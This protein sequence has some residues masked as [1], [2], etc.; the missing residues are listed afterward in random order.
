MK[1]KKADS[2]SVSSSRTHPLLVKAYKI[3]MDY[4]R[5]TGTFVCVVDRNYMPIQEMYNDISSE[6]NTCLFCIKYK[7][8]A[9]V[10]RLQDLHSNP[11]S[12]IHVNAIKNA[13]RFGGS[14]LYM[15]DLGFMFWTS[16]LFSEGR[17]IGALMGSGFLGMDRE[18]TAAQMYLMG[19]GS[20]AEPELRERLADFPR[21]D[22]I[23]IKALAE[24]MLICAESL[25]TGSE[26]YHETLR[27]RA[28][29]QSDIS[30]KI[31]ELKKKYPSGNPVPGYPL[32]KE[33]MLL[34][35]LRRGNTEAGRSILNELISILLFSYPDQFKYIQYR[36]MELAVLLSRADTIPGYPT[37]ALIETNNQYLQ[38]IQEA[39]N[40]EELT[41]ILHT[42]VDSMAGQI[43]SFR[44]IRHAT[45]L[46]KA[47][48][49][50]W[51][52]Y[53]RKIS[54]QE[55]ADASEL[56]APY[57][58]TIFKEEMGEN[59]SSFLNHLRVEKAC[60]ML[61]ET[62]LSLSK[63]AAACG[64][65]DQSW[66]SKIFKSYLG[67]SPGRYREQGGI[68][69]PEISDNSFSDDYRSMIKN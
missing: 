65:E 66:F 48:Q 37:E 9:M 54:L 28:E 33:K 64:F 18:E 58:S 46:K 14:Y 53:T 50:I 38:R 69:A 19:E 13:H 16:P 17:F 29:Q 67:I 8:K 7:A 34:A 57:F 6:K 43:S 35:A 40:I 22:S 42:I 1:N 56:S 51:E 21:G 39:E 36:A 49:F 26:K 2:S 5:A 63:I 68:S 60:Y 11:C 12:E 27:R 10:N 55:I 25:S 32:E 24:L 45:A 30:N 61:T 47:E 23:Q 15:C 4:A 59:L 31:G 62:D 44:G 52:N 20:V 41:D 3:I